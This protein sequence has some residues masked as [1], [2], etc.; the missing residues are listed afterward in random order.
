METYVV[1]S[2]PA[3]ICGGFSWQ[4]PGAART[5]AAGAG[6]A[7]PGIDRQP[8]TSARRT[9]ARPMTAHRH[10]SP[11]SHP[12]TRRRRRSGTRTPY[13]C[14]SLLLQLLTR[15]RHVLP[16]K[17]GKIGITRQRRRAARGACV[18]CR[19]PMREGSQPHNWMSCDYIELCRL[20][21]VSDRNDSSCRRGGPRARPTRNRM[22]S[23]IQ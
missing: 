18:L 11:G 7:S 10:Q 3:G 14:L 17:L 5:A 1:N 15:P 20:Q 2:Q 23:L 16:T 8:A 4:R 12:R 22:I 13:C 9:P 19:S 21:M 6:S